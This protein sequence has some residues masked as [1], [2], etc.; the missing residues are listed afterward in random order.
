MYKMYYVHVFY[1]HISR[2]V[3]FLGFIFIQFGL[4]ILMLGKPRKRTYRIDTNERGFPKWKGNPHRNPYIAADLLVSFRCNIVGLWHLFQDE[5]CFHKNDWLVDVVWLSS[6]N[7]Q[8]ALLTCE[9]HCNC[10]SAFSAHRRWKER[11][12]TCRQPLRGFAT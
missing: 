4:S 1:R 12:K 2:C 8:L 9:K 6:P 3:I 5:C 11:C 7:A 10:F